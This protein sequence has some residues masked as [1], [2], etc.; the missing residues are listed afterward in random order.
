MA[1]PQQ[2]KRKIGEQS[3][4][5]AEFPDLTD[6]GARSPSAAAASS[7]GGKDHGTSA[8][9]SSARSP[10]CSSGASAAVGAVDQDSRFPL[11]NAKKVTELKAECERK[12]IPVNSGIRK[13]DIIKLLLEHE[14]EVPL[15]EYLEK[16][17]PH[18][19]QERLIAARDLMAKF[20]HMSALERSGVLNRYK[21]I[22][23]EQ[24]NPM[25]SLRLVVLHLTQLLPPDV[26]P[27]DFE[28]LDEPQAVFPIDKDGKPIEGAAPVRS[29]S[30]QLYHDI[31]N[32]P[33]LYVLLPRVMEH[34]RNTHRYHVVMHRPNSRT[35][36]QASCDS[37]AFYF[38][39]AIA[40]WWDD[41]AKCHGRPVC[42][43]YNVQTF[44]AGPTPPVSNARTLRLY[45]I[46][47]RTAKQ[48]PDARPFRFRSP[49]IL[50]FDPALD[51]PANM[52]GAQANHYRFGD[53]EVRLRSVGIPV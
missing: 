25:S 24:T 29:V 53:I 52:P 39:Y 31:A 42:P 23:V 43:R 5:H 15:W 7:P 35:C 4:A 36:L 13:V 10:P 22:I 40:H 47:Q 28:L 41:H 11:L 19:N 30:G 14:D 9:S 8:S 37:F 46:L 16:N 38:L 45:L 3:N 12:N 50:F 32:D 17:V 34:L 33:D 48:F 49:N 1:P 27:T 18:T 6:R 44:P 20:Q 51:T 2:K 21:G 26:H